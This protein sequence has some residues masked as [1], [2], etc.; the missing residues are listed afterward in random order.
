MSSPA[1]LAWAKSKFIAFSCTATGYLATFAIT[2]APAAVV[3]SLM[4][5]ENLCFA[6]SVGPGGGSVDGPAGRSPPPS[7][8]GGAASALPPASG[9]DWR[10]RRCR[11]LPAVPLPPEPPEPAAGAA[12][13]SA[14]TG[15]R[16][17]PPD[18]LVRRCRPC[19]ADRRSRNRRGHPVVV[20]SGGWVPVRVLLGRAALEQAQG[21]GEERGGGYGNRTSRGWMWPVPSASVPGSKTISGLRDSYR[22]IPVGTARQPSP[23]L[24]APRRFARRTGRGRGPGG[25]CRRGRR[26]RRPR[27]RRAATRSAARGAVEGEEAAEGGQRD[28]AIAGDQGWGPGPGRRSRRP[29]GRPG[30]G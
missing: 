5:F 12:T 21:H 28:G 9:V 16:T 4:T 2:G 10:S 20:V 29:G 13:S 7:P 24:R 30:A 11:P 15:L 23:R 27:R 18:P 6:R 26:R 3:F 14:G 25:G 1:G 19:A 17:G 8:P 22:V